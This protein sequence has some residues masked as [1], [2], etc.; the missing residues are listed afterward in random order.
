MSRTDSSGNRHCEALFLHNHRLY[1]AVHRGFC[2]IASSLTYLKPLFLVYP[3]Y[4]SK[5]ISPFKRLENT[6]EW[7]I[8]NARWIQVPIYLGLIVV[9]LL[10]SY[11]FCCEVFDHIVHISSL[12]EADML[13]ITLG[14]VDV[15][16]IFNLIIVVIMGGYWTFVSHLGISE[17]DKDGEQFGHLG[18]LSANSL[19]IKLLVSL[20][21]ISAVHLLESFVRHD[22]E[23]KHI[24]AQIAIHLVFIISALAMTFMDKMTANTH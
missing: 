21:S 9:M 17:R 16:M 13:L 11:V 19:K 24:A 5:L 12:Q 20:I 4:M 1:L 6:I 23:P 10:Y 15:S 2:T 3:S 7:I 8:Y 14:L 18:N 22:V